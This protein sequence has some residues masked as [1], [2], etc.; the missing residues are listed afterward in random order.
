MLDDLF[1][2][3]FHGIDNLLALLILTSMKP[4][5]FC[6][7]VAWI[8]VA[9][10][11]LHVNALAQPRNTFAPQQGTFAPVIKEA[12]PSVVNIY[13]TKTVR[14]RQHPLMEHPFF[15]DFFEADPGDE[16]P[17]TREEQS[18][19]SGVIV[20]ADGYILTNNHV[21]EGADDIRVVLL[22]NGRE[23]SARIVGTDPPTDI[24]VLKIDGSEFPTARLGDSDALEIGDIVLAI[25][26][27]FGVGQTVTMGI[28]S[29]T[30][31]G[32]FG[33]VDY[34]DFVQ[35]DASI[36]VGNSGTPGAR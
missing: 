12:A 11:G 13:S 31:R 23:H 14:L 21:I 5:K 20:T 22:P 24:A 33:I 25:G 15:R 29:A 34:E 26:N 6:W 4:G 19:G 27:P 32:G 36:S 1:G 16:R 28:V 18:L 2:L 8:V 10:W 9:H 17:R 3:A 35:T 7:G 30:G